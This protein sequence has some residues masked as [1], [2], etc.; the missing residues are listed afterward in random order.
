[1]L[2]TRAVRGAVTTAWNRICHRRIRSC[3][4]VCVCGGITINITS[5]LFI[6]PNHRPCRYLN[7]QTQSCCPQ[8]KMGLFSWFLLSNRSVEIKYGREKQTNRG[9][10]H[11]CS[12]NCFLIEHLRLYLCIFPFCSESRPNTAVQQTVWNF[13][14][15]LLT[16]L[17]PAT[18][19]TCCII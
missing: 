12:C 16:S 4:C 17:K 8:V 11:F 6:D 9:M 13:R 18:C 5:M 1:M 10:S 3:V 7:T 15:G 2:N 19:C 14:S